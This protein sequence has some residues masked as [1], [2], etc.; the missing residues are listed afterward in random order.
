M[1]RSDHGSAPP[2]PGGCT[3]TSQATIN[4]QISTPTPF[5]RPPPT[6]SRKCEKVWHTFADVDLRSVQ[7]NLHASALCSKNAEQQAHTR[8]Q[9]GWKGGM[10]SAAAPE[11]RRKPIDRTR[12]RGCILY[13]TVASDSRFERER[14]TTVRFRLLIF[15]IHALTEH[16]T[17]NREEDIT[18]WFLPL[19][20]EPGF[21]GV[22]ALL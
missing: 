17:R 15:M 16:P 19:G 11:N 12:T 2:V 10:C 22:L 4:M 14:S 20:P 18:R 7:C 9:Q 13:A 3:A 1:I 8:T 21:C 5:Q 6:H